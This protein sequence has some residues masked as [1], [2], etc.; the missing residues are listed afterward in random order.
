MTS[1]VGVFALEQMSVSY[2]SP[3][4]KANLGLNNANI[5][6]L[7]SAYWLTFACSSCLTSAILNTMGAPKR[8]LVTIM[9]LL[10]VGPVLSGLAHSFTDLLA[11][12]VLMGCVEGP[13][14]PLCQ[15]I[16][17]LESPP[18]ARGRNTGIVGGL[19]VSLLGMV[20]G[21]LILVRVA[22]QFGW[23]SGFYVVVLPGLAC[24]LALAIL[25]REPDA[26]R[27]APGVSI[28]KS[29]EA[30]CGLLEIFRY[31]NIWL[32]IAICC[33]YLA[34]VSLGLTFLPLFYIEVRHVSPA[35]MS[36]LMASLGLSATFYSILLPVLSDGLGR[37][38]VMMLAGALSLLCPLGALYI[39]GSVRL[40]ILVPLATWSLSGT[41]GFFMGTIPAETVPVRF[42]STAI[43]L[44]VALGVLAGGMLGPPLAGWSADRWGLR[45][46]LWLEA[47]CGLAFLTLSFCLRE[48]TLD[49]S[50]DCMPGDA[51]CAGGNG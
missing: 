28:A 23:R 22:E 8:A 15:S 45:A 35:A 11:A 40:L 30:E 41:A 50:N 12:R 44:I 24:T 49:R 34:Y 2:L 31:R 46:A 3:F 48:T 1:V 7:L 13:V 32:C 27:S 36:W 5:A 19:G 51:T 37:R 26:A 43:G 39:S 42:V 20:A 9:A 47:T 38:V 14:I 29:A 17:A 4:I 18:G 6:Q 25:M 10:S 33:F 21:P 16:V